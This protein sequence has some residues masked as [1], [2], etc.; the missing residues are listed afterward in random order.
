MKKKAF[1]TGISGQDGSY[2]SEHLLSLDYEVYGIIRR[3]SVAENQDSRII[4]LSSKINTEYGDLMDMSSVERLLHSI[5]PNEV[6]NLAAQSHVGVSFK[7]PQYTIQVNSLGVANMLEAFRKECPTA[8]FYQATSSEIFG[9]SVDS[10]NFQRETT[11][12]TP[13]SPYGCSK[14]FSYHLV[15][16]YRK[17]YKLFAANGILFNHGSVRRGSN[18]VEQKI[19]MTAVDIKKGK[20]DKLILGNMD[21]YRDWGCSKDYVKAMHKILNHSEPDDFVISTGY[22]SS[23]RDICKF[24]FNKLGMDYLDYVVQDEK[25]IRPEELPFLRGDSTKAQRVLG[26]KPEYTVEKMLEEMIEH[27]MSK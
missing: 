14:L 26:W 16:N 6:Y 18:F 24:V 20:T 13:V 27:W 21:S 22:A 15:R 3:N 1:I 2:L 12:K 19:V 8:K 5:R 25:F 11:E 7:I 10:D 17:A 9:D 23:V 4:H